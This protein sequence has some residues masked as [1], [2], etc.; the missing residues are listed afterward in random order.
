MIV[1][2]FRRDVEIKSAKKNVSVSMLTIVR[3]AEN[4]IAQKIENS[5]NIRYPSENF[6][7]IIVTDGSTDETENIIKSFICNK[8]QLVSLKQHEGKNMAIDRGIKSCIGEIVIFSDVDAI[9]E[10]DTILKLMELF[11]D[12]TVGGVC[13]QRIIYEES[14]GLKYAQSTYL[15]FDSTIKKLESKI[16]SISSNDGKLYA[17]R[18]KL[19]EPIHP[20]VTDDLYTALS[21]IKQH[22]RFVFE[23]DAKAFVKIPSRNPRHELER[24]RRIVCRSLTGIFL[25]KELL[26]PFKYG[27]FSIRLFIN[28]ILR[29]FLPISMLLMFLSSVFLSFYIP[30]IRILVILQFVFYILAFSYLI[31]F[32]NIK[33]FKFIKRITSLAYYFCLG[34]YGTLLGLIDFIRGKKVVKWEPFKAD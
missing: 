8:L 25:Q 33:G 3:N 31:V 24:R 30:L 13:G 9:L 11:S 17:I 18:R 4:I 29:R 20:A 5:L 12:P 15:K 6:K 32:H 2:L 27:I 26:N 22:Y 14:K 19:F 28:K 23:P 34:N 10:P 21:I 1:S 7:I 16:G